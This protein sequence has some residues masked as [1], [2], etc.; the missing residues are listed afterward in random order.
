MYCWHHKHGFH[1]G[2]WTL[3]MGH[4][5][6]DGTVSLIF[7]GCINHSGS[8]DPHFAQEFTCCSHTAAKDG[9]PVCTVF[10]LGKLKRKVAERK[11]QCYTSKTFRGTEHST[12]Q[13]VSCSYFASTLHLHQPALCLLWY[14]VCP[15]NLCI[16]MF[17]SFHGPLNILAGDQN[18]AGGV[19]TTH[20]A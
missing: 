5:M 2:C 9:F 8:L 19:Y 3:R 15:L 13:I 17:L 4:D 6:L 7:H 16:F 10:I 1:D 12:F 14:L 18:D 20:S 11:G